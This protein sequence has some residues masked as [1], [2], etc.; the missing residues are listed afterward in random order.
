M[1]KP[2][3]RMQ[4]QNTSPFA[5]YF[6]NRLREGILIAV[7]GAAL[8]LL[9][10]LVTHTASDPVW[11]QVK[12][13]KAVL[14]LGGRAGAFLSDFLLYLFGY[15][16]Y[17]LPFMLFYAAWLYFRYSPILEQDYVMNFILLR[18]IGFI[19]LFV[20]GCLLGSLHWRLEPPWLSGGGIVG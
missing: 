17:L 8:F 6:R 16:A 12:H 9:L 20:P 2:S 7:G 19:C 4:P 14:N 13:A 3:S 10:A 5:D 11:S 18:A 1:T 15:L